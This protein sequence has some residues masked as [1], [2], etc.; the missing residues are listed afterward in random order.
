[1]GVGSVKGPV[2]R[3]FHSG[4]TGPFAGFVDIGAQQGAVRSD[5]C[6]KI[7]AYGEDGRTFTSRRSRLWTRTGSCA[8]SAAAVM[9]DVQSR[10][11]SWDEPAERVVAAAMANGTTCSAEAWRVNRARSLDARQPWWRKVRA[12]TEAGDGEGRSMVYCGVFPP[13]ESHDDPPCLICCRARGLVGTLRAEQRA[14]TGQAT[15]HR[16]H[17]RAA[18]DGTT[19]MFPGAFR[20]VGDDMYIGGQPTEKAL[21]EMKAQGVTTVV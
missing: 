21:R 12:E 8:A 17:R 1:M 14:E 6:W 10:L 20:Q 4:D 18:V 15:V 5:A 16:H 7:G 9:G 19:G 2:H 11:P 13:S 3:L